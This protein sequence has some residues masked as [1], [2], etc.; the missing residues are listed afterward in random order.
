MQ[1]AITY[2]LDHS[3]TL[4]ASAGNNNTS[5]TSGPQYPAAYS[6][7][8]STAAT[9]LQEVKTSFSNYGPTIEMDALGVN[10]LSAAPGNLYGC[11]SG[12]AFSVLCI[13]VTAAPV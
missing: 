5:L 1:N 4:V 13:D 6:G 8:I 2:A 9:N 11:M 10:I 3:V 7:V 12:T